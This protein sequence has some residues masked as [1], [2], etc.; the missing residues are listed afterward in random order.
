M[1]IRFSARPENSVD[2]V[3][4]DMNIEADW[5]TRSGQ[6]AVKQA[7]YQKYPNC[8]IADYGLAANEPIQK[9]CTQCQYSY[10]D[11][12]GMFCEHPNI[13]GQKGYYTSHGK[14]RMPIP[15]WCPLENAKEG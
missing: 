3:Y 1:K 5:N 13:K 6:Q 14:E 12:E 2:Y 15:D 11:F 8:H 4:E 7:I 10:Y 9:N